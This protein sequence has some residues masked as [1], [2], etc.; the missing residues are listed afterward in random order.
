MRPEPIALAANNAEI[1]GG[2]VMLLALAQ[3]LRELGREVAVVGPSAP[4]GVLEAAADR[5]F[6]V[7]E[8][9]PARAAYVR[10][11]RRWDRRERDGLLWCNGLVPAV[12]TTGRARRIVHLHAGIAPA[13]R[14]LARAARVG[15]LATLAPSQ[16]LAQRVPGAIALP[17]WT[18]DLGEVR[19]RSLAGPVV[20]GFLGRPSVIKG[21]EVL[22]EACAQLAGAGDDIR[23]VIA[24]EPRFIERAEHVRVQ[25]A[26]AALGERVTRM[27]WVEPRT[28]FAAV[29]V[30]VF[31]SIVAESFGLVAAEAMSAR[32]PLIVSDAGAL[33]EVVGPDHPWI[34][35]AGD[36][37]HLATVIRDALTASAGERAAAVDAA[38][39]RWERLYSPAAGRE[40][41][42]ELLSTLDG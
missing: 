21:A 17:N 28:F 14:L 42:A 2:E 20:L 13:H 19:P 32:V 23:L 35:R 39:A 10:A 3:V 31:P 22:A 16:D 1:G 5:G 4:G 7:V 26:L 15:A 30:A 11:L 41:V 12:A 37:T 27:G 40:R 6:A 9:A 38:R 18:A 24:G 36:P 34:A 33:P 29:D 25:R 8:L